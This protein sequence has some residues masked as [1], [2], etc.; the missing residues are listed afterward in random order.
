MSDE[1]ETLPIVFAESLRSI[2]DKTKKLASGSKFKVRFPA[3]LNTRGALG[4]EVAMLQLLGT[5]I[6]KNKNKKVFHSFQKGEADDFSKLCE[7]LY[8]IAVLSMVDEIWDAQQ[9]RLKKG[10]ALN[11]AKPTIEKLRKNNYRGC[12]KGQYFGVPYIKTKRYDKELDMLFYDAGEIIKSSEFYGKIKI[13][14]DKMIAAKYMSKS[15]ESIVDSGDLAD[16]LW[17]LLKNTHDHGRQ[18][19]N[20]NL[21]IENFRALIIQQQDITNAY[22]DIWCGDNPSRAQTAF[23]EIWAGKAE[24]H[25]FFDLSV[26][27]FGAG[28][29]E[30][31]KEKYNGIGNKGI[32]LKC[33]EKGW[34]RFSD[35]SRGDGLTKVLDCV[36]NHKGWIRIRTSNL[37]LEKTYISD[38][39]SSI[40]DSDIEEMETVVAGTSIHI[41]LPLKRS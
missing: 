39:P 10:L 5:W 26:I 23:K 25:Y 9:N 33:L 29:V 22:F 2:E 11:S 36:H 40:E 14:T 4:I 21:A 18:E 31:A 8:G 38:E 7:S 1:Y 35:K 34:S 15:L 27:D 3:S 17:E 20:G 24:K 32:F 28:Y 12:F 19:T 37:L 16:I 41:S 6:K 13:I 30:L